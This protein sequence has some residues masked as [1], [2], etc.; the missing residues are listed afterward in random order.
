[1]IDE[2]LK[3]EEKVRQLDVPMC[4]GVKSF[5]LGHA[6]ADAWFP[7]TKEAL[8]ELPNRNFLCLFT[9]KPNVMTSSKWK[10]KEGLSAR[11]HRVS[12]VHNAFAA[13]LYLF[14]IDLEF[15]VA[16]ICHYF[17]FAA[18]N[19]DMKDVLRVWASSTWVSETCAQ[20]LV[21]TATWICSSPWTVRGS[22]SFFIR[23]RSN[24][25][26]RNKHLAVAVCKQYCSTFVLMFET[27]F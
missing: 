2:T 15:L 24:S 25:I 19:T 3:P 5:H 16:N 7:S 18:R 9:N 21:E 22:A 8:V 11:I 20:P 17:A 10:V 26:T 6:T 1:M 12:E 23:S 13:G 14:S 27:L 4:L